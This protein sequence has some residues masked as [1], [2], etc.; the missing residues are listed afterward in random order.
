MK[1]VIPSLHARSTRFF[2]LEILLMTLVGLTIASTSS[3]QESNAAPSKAFIDYFL[4]TPITASLSKDAW[5]APEVGPRDTKNGLEDTTIK[6]WCYW[7]GQIIK[8]PDGK[9]H[10]FASRWDQAKGHG[11]WPSSQ[12]VQ[13]VSDNLTGPYI[14]K[15]L[16]WPNDQGGKGHNVT[17]LVLPDGRYAVVVSETRPGDVF[18]SKSLDGPWENLGRIRIADNEFKDLGRPSNMSMM[19]RPDGDFE[20]VPRSG[21]ILISKTGVLGPYT[22]QG[23]GVYPKVTGLL[24]QD[25]EDP[26]VWY[27]GGLYHI[28]VNSWSNR[29]AF[30]LTSVD[31]INDWKL[32][33]VAYDPTKDFVRYTDGTINHWNKMERPGVY[34]EN[35]HVAAVT[36]AVIDVPK[37]NEKGNDLHGS[38]VIVIPFDGAAMDSDLKKTSAATP[39]APSP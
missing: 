32:Q 7:D 3:G 1:N 31:G 10:L 30:H 17:A 11:G 24:Q 33:G 13:A 4:P 22:V 19:V 23:P 39:S 26:V 5:G 2:G 34:I 12:A 16:L 6:Q 35:G 37:D 29:K 38:K 27:S 21:A 25:L 20:I 14:D 8:A 36:L 18:V 28:V 15:G 9:Y